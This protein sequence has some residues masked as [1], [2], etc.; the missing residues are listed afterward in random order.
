MPGAARHLLARVRPW[1]VTLGCGAALGLAV[2]LLAGSVR[3][4]WP[5]T[6]ALG[7]MA[8]DRPATKGV[9]W[10]AN[11][12]PSAETRAFLDLLR[13]AD[14]EGLDPAAYRIAAIEEALAETNAAGQRRA[15]ALLHEALAAYARDLAVPRGASDVTYIDAELAPI[16]PS[17]HV[18]AAGG[19]PTAQLRALHRGNPAYREL[20]D[21]LARYRATWSALPQVA[22]PAGSPLAP[23][24]RGVRV[25]L[26]RQR[27]GLPAGDR[28]DTAL[29]EAIRAFRETHGLAPSPI[30]GAATIAALNRGATHYEALVIADMDRLRGIPARVGRHILVDTGEASLR[31]I[32]DGKVVDRM[33]VVV[34]KPGMDTPMLAGFIRY[35]LVNPYWN[36]PPDLVRANVAPAVIREG[37][38]VLDRKRYVLSADWR[39]T[40]RLD[41]AA[42]DWPAVAA[43]RSSVWV[44]QL[45]GAGNM[46]GAVKFMLPNAMGIYLHDTPAKSLFRR[47][48]RRLSSG[49]VRL[50]DAPRLARWLLGRPILDGDPAPDRRVDLAEPV[51]VFALHLA[52]SVR[53]GQLRFTPGAERRPPARPPSAATRS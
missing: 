18:L 43:G 42:V 15:E 30:A 32:E 7:A 11:G 22:I 44:R 27:L 8:D 17:A 36:M 51:P 4:P 49:C 38:R 10:F 40:E 47:A 19:A 24:S 37:P 6:A 2:P 12:Q 9:L 31:M 1:A 46:M 26:L 16:A 13:D 21:A 50:E 41:P 28:H 52:T 53:D 25:A 14:T 29:G 5:L 20:R 35:A 39:T 3:A 34:G 33:R 45:P 23:G 48:D